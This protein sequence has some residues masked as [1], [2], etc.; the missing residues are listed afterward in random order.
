MAGH[1]Q[2]SRVGIHGAYS[3]GGDVEESELGFGGQL[4]FPIN[5]IFSVELAMSQFSDEME[6]DGTK[7]DQDLTSI[8]LSAI[9]RGPIAPQ[10]DGYMLMGGNYNI[11]DMDTSFSSPLVYNGVNYSVDMDMDDEVG[12][13]VGA[14]L[15]FAVSYNMEFFAEYRYTFLETEGETELS[16]TDGNMTVILPIAEGDYEYNFGVMKVGMNFLF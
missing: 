10:L 8:G 5:P 4:E 13:H 1:A 3:N 2:A 7:I 9:F 12:F 6:G 15:N 11:F 14:G 16:G